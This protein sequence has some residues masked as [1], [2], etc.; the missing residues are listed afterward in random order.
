MTRVFSPTR[1]RIS[2]V[3]P[4]ALIV[5]PVIASASATLSRASTV[6]TVPLIITRSAE[7]GCAASPDTTS[8]MPHRA[9]GAHPTGDHRFGSKTICLS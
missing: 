8:T 2:A 7:A 5:P 3:V 4:T 6:S 9:C 1:F